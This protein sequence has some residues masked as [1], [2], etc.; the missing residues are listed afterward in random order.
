[1]KELLITPR[2]S[3]AARAILEWQQKDLAVFAGLSLSAVK[4]FESGSQKTRLKTQRTLQNTFEAHQIEFPLTGG[5][6]A[7]EDIATIQ[8]FT[9]PSF[10][11]KWNEDIYKACT[12][13]RQPILTSSA[14]EALWTTPLLKKTNDVFLAWVKDTG[15]SLKVLT[16]A[17]QKKLNMEHKMYRTV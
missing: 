12:D 14:G 6:R 8:R 7:I 5:V 15:I 13:P 11:A 3:R 9:G 2:L 16:P 4:E 10:M 1:M 17:G